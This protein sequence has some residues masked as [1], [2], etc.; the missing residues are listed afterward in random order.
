MIGDTLPAVWTPA[1]APVIPEPPRISKLAEQVAN[2]FIWSYPN[3]KTRANY[4]QGLQHWFRFCVG[5]G[6]DPLTGLEGQGVRRSDVEK[7]LRY[8]EDI[9]GLKRRTVAGRYCA[10]RGFFRRARMD[11]H[12]DKD[13]TEF[14]RAPVVE[15]KTTTNDMTRRQY[16]RIMAIAEKRSMRDFAIFSILGQNGF[17]NSELCGIDIEDLGSSRGWMT[18]TIHR[19]GG[20]TETQ[21]FSPQTAWAVQQHLEAEGRRTGPLFVSRRNP[22]NRLG[23]HDLHALVKRYAKW[24]DI[25]QSISPHSFR[26]FFVTQCRNAG[27][28]DREIMQATGHADSRMI[29]YYDHGRQ[30]LGREATSGVANYIAEA[31][32]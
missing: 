27:I 2:D 31:E 20:K 30:G 8:A 13:P 29:E 19:K 28:K 17:R 9:E 1:P 23:T 26:H 5:I 15:R 21:T 25:Q 24:A 6:I 14:V 16:L 22:A 11:G 32:S 10:I 3:A 4:A 12:L 7:F 18:A